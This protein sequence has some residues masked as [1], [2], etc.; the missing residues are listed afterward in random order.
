MRISYDQYGHLIHTCGAYMDVLS[1]SAICSECNERIKL[2]NINELA[3][4]N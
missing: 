3:I 4:D 1:I 2:N